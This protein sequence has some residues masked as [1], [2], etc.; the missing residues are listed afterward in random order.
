MMLGGNWNQ[1]FRSDGS[2]GNHLQ[3]VGSGLRPA[4]IDEIGTFFKIWRILS[5]SGAQL[6]AG[7]DLSGTEIKE[8][9]E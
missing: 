6:C 7:F 8:K 9:D 4:T 1:A 2:R 5:E 3:W